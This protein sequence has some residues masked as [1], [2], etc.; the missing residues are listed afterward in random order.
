MAFRFFGCLARAVIKHGGKFVAGLLPY[1]KAAEALYE[2]ATDAW[3]DF[4]HQ[5][6]QDALRREIESLAQASP[7]EIRQQAQ[8]AVAAGAASLSAEARQAAVT[9]LMQVPAMIRRSLRRPSDPGGTTVPARMALAR[10]DDLLPFLP[11]QPPRFKPGD[12]APGSDWVLEELLGMGGF[13]EVWKA[14]QPNMD[15][16]PPRAFKFCLDDAAI[17]S[18]RNEAGVLNQVKKNGRHPGIVGLRETHLKADPP[19]LEYEFVQGCDL[20]SLIREL[21]ASRRADI[22]TVNRRFLELVEIVAFAHQ[23][24][25]VHDDL[26][27]ANIL[28][29]QTSRDGA[30]RIT[31]FGIG[32]VATVVAAQESRLPTRSRQALLTEAVRGAYTPLYAPAEQMLRRPGEPADPRDD[33]HALGV[34]WYQMLT[35]DLSLMSVPADWRDEVQQRGLSAELQQLLA[36]CIAGKANKRPDNAVILA[37]RLRALLTPPR[38]GVGVSRRVVVAGAALAVSGLSCMGVVGLMWSPSPPP[39]PGNGGSSGETRP[40]VKPVPT[41]AVWNSS[42]AGDV[43]TNTLGMKFA[44]IPRGSFWMGGGGGT[45]GDKQ[46]T[47]PHD[48]FLGVY[49]V[50][51]KEWLDVMG[52]N[53]PSI[54]AKT[55]AELAQFPVENVSWD[56]V[57]EFCKKLNA[58]EKDSGWMYRLPTQEEWE[59]ACPGGVSSKEE[60]SFHFYFKQPTNDLSWDQASFDGSRPFGNGRKGEE[61]KST[62]KVGS[63]DPNRLGL[64]DMHGNVWE[65]CQDL[66]DGGPSRVLRGG[67][68]GGSGSVCRAA[69]RS[70]GQPDFRIP[71][72]GFRLARVP[73][74]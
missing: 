30:L 10:P 25:I 16:E 67:G 53:N 70:G 27:P 34:I 54:F 43:S 57:Q 49:E 31:D 21:H 44:Y 58:W 26:K 18:L 4:C 11:S 19:Y 8:S 62:T 12:H 68:W 33:I 66:Y 55:G 32:G 17:K 41:P 63:F 71:G 36:S 51:Q 50:T 20:A 2:M 7:N 40:P 60:C 65:W 69:S 74:K 39:G 48:F 6:D 3:Q 15:D 29:D 22:P 61:R 52:G 35:G 24:N 38:K 14:R 64:Y 72:L 46:V 47:I 45:P 13:G 28:V 23:A 73:V 56:M 9:Y 5:S 42:K 37:Q 59:Y 1:E